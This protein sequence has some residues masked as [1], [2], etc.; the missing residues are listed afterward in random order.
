MTLKIK[1]CT[2]CPCPQLQKDK[3]GLVDVFVEKFLLNRDNVSDG[4]VFW[5]NEAKRIL[6]DL[7]LRLVKKE[8]AQ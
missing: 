1:D 7:G 3:D 8:A 4:I 5:K 2:A 6:D